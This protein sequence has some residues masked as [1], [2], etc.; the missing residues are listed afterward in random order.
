M[1]LL[2][3]YTIILTIIYFRVQ[4]FKPVQGYMK[5]GILCVEITAQGSRPQSAIRRSGNRFG[6][7]SREKPKNL[8]HD[9]IQSER[10]ML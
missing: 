10:I 3:T 6:V 9:P 1:T 8:E 2:L 4:S 7:R 5:S